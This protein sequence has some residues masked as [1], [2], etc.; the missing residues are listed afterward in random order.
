MQK[1]ILI[2]LAG[3]AGALSRYALAGLA[4]RLA[5]PGFPWGTFT[6]NMLGS[7][8]FG[9]LWG[10]FENRI[11]ISGETRIIILTGFM[12]AF[13]TF[14]TFTFETATLLEQGQHLSALGNMAGQCVLGL[15]L[16]FGGIALGRML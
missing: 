1:L 6:V 7:L 14:S 5:G 10:L 13:T 4:Q 12:G 8:V 11:A 3:G 16:V 2:G 9:L 15:V